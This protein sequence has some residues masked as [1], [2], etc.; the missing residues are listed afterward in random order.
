MPPKSAT[1][2]D[3]IKPNETKDDS[4]K[5]L[6]WQKAVIKSNQEGEKQKCLE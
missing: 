3:Q 5:L 2:K 6:P 1:F 4:F